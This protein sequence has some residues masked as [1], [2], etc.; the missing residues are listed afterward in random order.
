MMV[1]TERRVRGRV[2]GVMEDG[3]VE[4]GL[5]VEVEGLSLFV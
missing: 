4:W 5:G 2:E 1:G 3:E